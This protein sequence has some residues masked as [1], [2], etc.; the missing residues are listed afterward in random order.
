MSWELLTE[1][2]QSS[3][4]TIVQLFITK[5]NNMSS[6]LE[7]QYALGEV[8]VQKQ[9]SGEAMIHFNNPA[10]KDLVISSSNPIDLMKVSGVTVAELKNSNLRDHVNR[11]SLVIL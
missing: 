11:G 4:K 1:K 9:A 3:V 8:S 2:L 7:K 5:E 10:I 6:A